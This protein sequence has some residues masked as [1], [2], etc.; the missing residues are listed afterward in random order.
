MVRFK[1]RYVLFEVNPSGGERLDHLKITEKHITQ[2]LRDAVQALYG[3]FGLGSIVKSLYMKRFT[4][5]TRLGIVSC[6]RGQHALL[7]SSLATVK[8][9]K[10]LNCS[11]RIVYL[12]GTIRG[13]LRKLEEYHR[14]QIKRH[15]GDL[16]SLQEGFD[17]LALSLQ[18]V[19]EEEEE[20]V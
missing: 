6:Q 16:K 20:D 3:D 4:P 11:I 15:Q 2:A 17:A 13:C 19:K 8:K 18:D 9:I 7:T 14:V 1:R 5:V 12:S 10:D